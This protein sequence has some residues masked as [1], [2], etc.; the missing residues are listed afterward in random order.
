MTAVTTGVNVEGILCESEVWHDVK[1]LAGGSVIRLVVS[2]FNHRLI[3]HV[4][5]S[6]RIKA[7]Q[8]VFVA[9]YPLI[10]HSPSIS[11]ISKIF[12]L[13]IN[14]HG[15]I[16]EMPHLEVQS[17]RTPIDRILRKTNRHFSGQIRLP[18]FKVPRT[19]YQT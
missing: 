2:F 4:L 7:R 6:C 11:S 5:H 15:P 16:R 18:L 19:S 1:G 14:I 13:Y 12:S 17:V 8:T 3:F 9:N 10:V